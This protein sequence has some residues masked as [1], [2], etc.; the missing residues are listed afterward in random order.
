MEAS[1]G[2]RKAV[3]DFYKLFISGDTA[4]ADENIENVDG[5]L[6]IGTDPREWWDE[7]ESVMST[8]K[9]QAG[10]MS[11]MGLRVKREHEI[12]AYEE[13]SIGWVADRPTFVLPDGSEIQLRTTGVFR[14]RVDGWKL[15]QWHA[16][17][18]VENEEALG[19]ELTI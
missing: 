15:V 5:L 4:F 10:E 19:Q 1:P 9:A 3:E 2:L 7:Y 18:G 16:S 13:G 6:V 14:E 11:R 12:E 17:L 8:L